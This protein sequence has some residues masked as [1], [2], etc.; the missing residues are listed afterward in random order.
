M[1]I[2]TAPASAQRAVADDNAASEIPETSDDPHVLGDAQWIQPYV[3]ADPISSSSPLAGGQDLVPVLPQLVE[4]ISDDTVPAH[5]V[6]QCIEIC[7][8]LYY[9]TGVE[10]RAAAW[11]GSQ[12]QCYLKSGKSNPHHKPGDTSFLLGV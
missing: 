12:K 2:P 10:C 7:T 5:N 3:L 11:N 8:R 9:V 1:G 6:T 4:R